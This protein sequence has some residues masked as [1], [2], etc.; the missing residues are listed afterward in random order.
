MG[1]YS[2][3]CF[4]RLWTNFNEAAMCSLAI[5]SVSDRY[6]KTKVYIHNAKRWGPTA[7]S[8]PW[9]PLMGCIRLH[10]LDNDIWSQRFSLKLHINKCS[11]HLSSAHIVIRSQFASD[12]GGAGH[13]HIWDV[14]GQEK[15]LVTFW[16]VGQIFFLRDVAKLHRLYLH[17]P[18][19]RLQCE[20]LE[21]WWHD[22]TEIQH[23]LPAFTPHIN[24]CFLL[25]R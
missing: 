8:C 13:Q 10:Y 23:V 18:E 16:L 11:H 21:M 14:P 24:V 3:G 17:P 22:W 19:I 20:K 15:Y 4:L 9:G 1:E 5:C 6:L 12:V 7:P 2:T 25:S